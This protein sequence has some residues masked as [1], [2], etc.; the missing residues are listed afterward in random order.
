[1]MTPNTPHIAMVDASQVEVLVPNIA[2]NAAGII[3]ATIMIVIANS[4]TF[5][6]S[7]LLSLRKVLDGIA[8]F[9]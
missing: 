5:P 8:F 9:A 3:A 6:A 4:I 2:P 7:A 1:M